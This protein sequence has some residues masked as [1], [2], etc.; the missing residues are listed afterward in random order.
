MTNYPPLRWPV[1]PLD[2]LRLLITNALQAGKTYRAVVRIE[3]A[4]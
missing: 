2:Q 1:G 3:E 4:R